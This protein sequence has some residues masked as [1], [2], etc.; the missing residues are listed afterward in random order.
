MTKTRR[1]SE[2]ILKLIYLK[3]KK[4]YFFTIGMFLKKQNSWVCVHHCTLQHRLY[5]FKFCRTYE[6]KLIHSDFSLESFAV[7]G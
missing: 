3:K 7:L 6:T 5:K 4:G 2:H 1:T